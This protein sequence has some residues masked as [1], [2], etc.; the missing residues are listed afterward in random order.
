MGYGTQGYLLRST[1]TMSPSR[2]VWE[3]TEDMLFGRLAYE[4]IEGT[5]GKGIGGPT[6]DGQLVVAYAIQKHFDIRRA[7]NPSTGE[8]LN[9]IEENT[10]DRPWYEREYMR[11]D[12]SKNINTDAY[13]FDT[14][15]A[16]SA[17][18]AGRAT[19]RSLTT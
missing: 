7:Y 17:P 3:V 2:I 19:S 10:T 15:L 18:S 1:F 14:L 8:E 4:R 6:P 5:D 13:D 12:W 16:C 9:V 11:V